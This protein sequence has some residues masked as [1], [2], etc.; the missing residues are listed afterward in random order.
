MAAIRTLKLCFFDITPGIFW[1][2]NL[3]MT[4]CYTLI[5]EIPVYHLRKRGMS[6]IDVYAGKYM[7]ICGALL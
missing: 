4:A 5:N 7:V 2:E 6:Y 3:L 1:F